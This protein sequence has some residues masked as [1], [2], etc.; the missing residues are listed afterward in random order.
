MDNFLVVRQKGYD[1]LL[2]ICESYKEDY[3]CS[4]HLDEFI[5]YSPA[6]TKKRIF[7]TLKKTLLFEQLFKEKNINQVSQLVEDRVQNLE[8]PKGAADF[9]KYM[10]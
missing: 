8:T 10:Y 7:K 2:K 3:D 4:Y 5:R 1:L 9:I 6:S